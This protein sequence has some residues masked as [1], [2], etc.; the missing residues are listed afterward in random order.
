MNPPTSRFSAMRT[1]ILPLVGFTLLSAAPGIQAAV[2]QADRAVITNTAV[3]PTGVTPAFHITEFEVYQQGTGTNVAAAL[4]GA[5]ATAS[6]TGWGTQPAWTIDGGRDGAFASNSTW[7]DT[8]GEVGDQPLL[9]D[10]L[11]VNFAALQTVDSFNVWG[12][13]DCCPERDDSFR[14][15][16]F[17]GQ[18]LV[19][20]NAVGIVNG[21]E[22]GPTS[23]T[24]IP[25]PSIGAGLLIGALGLLRV[26]RRRRI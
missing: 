19:G 3:T 17:N 14:V 15:D 26:V 12:R 16:F 13:S 1:S 18:T 22:L 7:H 23:I 25:E 20:S 8:D 4:A 6:S 10:V 11:T 9:P 5:A 24:Q 21:F 2:V